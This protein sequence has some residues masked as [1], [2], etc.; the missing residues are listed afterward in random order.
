MLTGAHGFVPTQKLDIILVAIPTM[1]GKFT[2]FVEYEP[3][4]S[5]SLEDIGS[6]CLR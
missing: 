6:I 2:R 5:T 1:V 3:T 4:A